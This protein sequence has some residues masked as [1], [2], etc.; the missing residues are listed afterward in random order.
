[1]HHPTRLHH[2]ISNRATSFQ[3]D[4]SHD[5]TSWA[6][7]GVTPGNRVTPRERGYRRITANSEEV[8]FLQ[9]VFCCTQNRL[10]FTSDSGLASLRQSGMSSQ[11]RSEFNSIQFKII[12]IAL[13]TIQSLINTITLQSKLSFYNRFIYCRNLIYLTYDKIWLILFIVWGVGIIS[14]QV[15]GHLGSLKGWI[16]TEACVIPS[17]HGLLSVNRL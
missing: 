9:P 16:Q 8:R 15:F 14:S 10:W 5:S 3:R 17:Y 2:T 11:H 6:G 13:F 12:C 4:L 7:Y 1:M